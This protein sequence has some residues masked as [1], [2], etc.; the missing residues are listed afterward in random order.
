MG[1]Y[2]LSTITSHSFNVA[3]GYEALLDNAASY[4]TGVGYQAL[5]NNT[6]SILNAA[7]GYQSLH[8]NTT[9]AQNT[10]LGGYALYSVSTGS[11][12]TGSGYS[13]LYWY[14]GSRNTAHGYG[15]LQSS[16]GA[17]GSDNTGVGYQAGTTNKTGSNNTFVG[18]AADA[19][20]N[21]YSNASAIGSNAITTATNRMY[22]GDANALLY[23]ALGVWS[24]S[25]GR[26]KTDVTENV[27]GINFI[28]KL[29]PVTYKMNTEALA[30]HITQNMPDSLKERYLVSGNFI[31]SRGI[32]R[33]GFIAQEVKAAAEE[34][35]FSSDIVHAPE[36]STDH[37]AINYA[38]IVVPL[39]KAVQEL[40]KTVDSL[41]DILSGG[42]GN[43]SIQNNTDIKGTGSIN[44]ELSDINIVVL[45]QNSPNPFAEQT[46][47]TYNIPA[48]ANHSQI[49]F[50]DS[51]GKLIKT[52]E[53]KNTG[54]G[55]L[56]VY[57]N[58]LTSGTFSYTLLIDGKIFDT[59][60]MMKQ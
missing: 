31:A 32:V 29:R 40:S 30:Q 44:V 10:A 35:G 50:Y 19:N 14:T 58:D 6:S 28:N 20:A 4:N 53:I 1:D 51:N 59:K 11:A 18:A 54:K 2:A 48:T 42:G 15:S 55:Q 17:T 37:Y 16:S 46:V 8:T 43:R 5:T 23:C 52:V 36:N 39:V 34:V 49:L 9:G 26:F 38:E 57:A 60:K 12:C 22:L 24:G 3:C 27:K 21:N 33:S 13:S 7:V 47:I 41:K 45:N 25:D 56:N